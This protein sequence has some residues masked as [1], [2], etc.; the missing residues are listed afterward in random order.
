MSKRILITGS[1]GLVGSALREHLQAL[2]WQVRGLDIRAVG[3]EAGDV[4]DTLRVRDALRGCA[5]VVHLAAVSRVIWG[6]TQPEV[7][8]ATNVY[9]LSNVLATALRQEAPPWVIFA[10]SREVYGQP[11]LLPATED[12]SLRPVNVYAR[13]KVKG[14]QLI[15]AARRDG[16]R[17]CVVRLSNVFGSTGDHHDRVVPAFAQA[18]VLGHTLRVDGSG[19][20]F[21]FTHLDDVTRGITAL[22]QRLQEG[23]EAPPPIHF[24]SGCPTTLGQL[25]SMA[26][27]IAASGSTITHAQPRNFDVAR[28]YGSPERARRLLGWSPRVSLR[29]GLT[30][31]INDFREVLNLNEVT[32]S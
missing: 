28:F 1:E 17:A 29:E 2:G 26:I 11:D 20:T 3:A 4:R 25:A 30:R 16:L 32:E 10:S 7:C 9:G 12:T 5:G 31:L 15:A 18:A 23:G 6:E 27:D 22:I 13:T 21:D 19:H 24:V 8:R 14:E